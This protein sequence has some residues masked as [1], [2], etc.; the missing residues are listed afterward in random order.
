[1]K[2]LVVLIG[3]V[4]FVFTACNNKTTQTEEPQQEP[5]QEQK[6]EEQKGCCSEM[7]E[8]Q[9]AEMEAWKDWDNQTDERKAELVASGKACLDKMMAE[10][11][12]CC[13]QKEGEEKKE[14]CKDKEAKCA[15]MKAKFDNWDNMT[16]EEKKALLDGVAACCK[17]KCCK[18]G[19]KKEEGCGHDHSDPNHKH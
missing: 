7:T 10:K 4:C 2:K 9:K 12:S 18:E 3:L 19:E 17:E 1:M 6:C 11:K 5:Q 15:E 13:E 8:E 14:C 16:V